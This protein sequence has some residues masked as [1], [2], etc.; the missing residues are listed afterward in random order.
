MTEYTNAEIMRRLDD[1]V[2]QN[3]IVLAEIKEDRRI[4]AERYVTKEIHDRDVRGY[5]DAH[6]RDIREIHA[7]LHQIVEDRKT[8][9]ADKKKAED[10]WKQALFGLGIQAVLMLATAFIAFSNFVA[11]AGG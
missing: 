6:D 8:D 4:L 3:T 7:D 1:L 2:R 9:V 10:R 11:R 5:R